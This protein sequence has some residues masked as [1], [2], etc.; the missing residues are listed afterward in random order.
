METIFCIND[1][2][3][4]VE[5]SGEIDHHVADLLRKD[6]DIEMQFYQMLGN[7]LLKKL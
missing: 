4:I 6:I 7:L 2:T 3:L 5:L 1:K